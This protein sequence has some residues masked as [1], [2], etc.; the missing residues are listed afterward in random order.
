MRILVVED[1][2]RVAASIKKGLEQERFS[3]DAVHD[4]ESGLSYGESDDYDLII[5]DRMLPGGMD[6][7]EICAKWRSA[8]IKTPVLILTARDQVPDKVSGLNLGADDY[9]TK[10]FAFDELVARVRALLRRP[11][12]NQSPK[13][14]VEN[15]ELDPSKATITRDGRDISLTSREFS[16]LEYLMNNAGTVI[17]K[18]KLLQHLWNDDADILPNTIEVYISYIRGKLDQPGDE[19]FI[20]TIRGFGYRVG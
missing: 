14:K 13:L 20:K 6:G 18:D 16:V 11:K 15:V 10:P 17:S 3:V 5:L 7:L 8:G 12:N 4:G 2:P 9:M 1:E 19:P